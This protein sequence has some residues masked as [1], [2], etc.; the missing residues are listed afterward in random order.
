MF[1]TVLIRIAEKAL[2]L[3][4]KHIFFNSE[5]RRNQ[6]V[7]LTASPNQWS[8]IVVPI[9]LTMA[10]GHWVINERLKVVL[11]MAFSLSRADTYG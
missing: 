2:S 7:V 10:Y 5:L 1:C 8:C 6:Y 3:S 9:V 4:F 11:E